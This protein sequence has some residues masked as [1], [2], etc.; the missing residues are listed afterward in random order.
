MKIVFI[1]GSNRGKESASIKPALAWMNSRKNRFRF[2]ILEVGK[3]IKVLS[4]DKAF[5]DSYL[6]AMNTS[7]AVIWLIPVRNL[8]PSFEICAF[9]HLINQNNAGSLLKNKHT[10]AVMTSFFFASD[11]AEAYL[12]GAC[13]SWE[14]NWFAAFHCR[15]EKRNSK[16][17]LPAIRFLDAFIEK[18]EKNISAPQFY[19]IIQSRFLPYRPVAFRPVKKRTDS[20]AKILLITATPPEETNLPQMI[21]TWEKSFP[22]PIEKVNLSEL[23]LCF[24]CAGKCGCFET[25]FCG[26]ESDSIGKILLP[27]YK[28]ADVVIFAADVRFGILPPLFK[29]FFDRIFI[30]ARF[31]RQKKKRTVWLLS[32]NLKNRSPLQKYIR[33]K[34]ILHGE[35]VIGIANDGNESAKQITD[36]LFALAQETAHLCET[37]ADAAADGVREENLLEEFDRK[38]LGTPPSHRHFRSRRK[39]ETMRARYLHRN[40]SGTDR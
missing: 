13:Q 36:A 31:D 30:P 33:T 11:D 3:Y 12:A 23:P 15:P 1:A 29:L 37:E 16:N 34:S 21:E 40:S 27:K 5:F 8:L 10:T 35:E 26:F 22:L 14:M 2:E 39:I 24:P 19:V 25:R 9:I 32:G 28:S 6:Q 38:L 17:D 4:E 18:K 7:D 20:K